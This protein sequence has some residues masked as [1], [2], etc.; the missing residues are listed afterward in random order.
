MLNVYW[1]TH[2]TEYRGYK[3]IIKDSNLLKVPFV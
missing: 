2:A 1:G 3:L